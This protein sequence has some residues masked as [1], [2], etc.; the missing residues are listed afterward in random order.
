MTR[1]SR[2]SGRT[3][4]M[5]TSTVISHLPFF[6]MIISVPTELNCFHKDEFSSSIFTSSFG[7]V[8][9]AS[10]ET[11]AGGGGASSLGGRALAAASHAGGNSGICTGASRSVGKNKSKKKKLYLTGESE[12]N[13][14]S[15]FNCILVN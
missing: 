4:S 1:R 15:Y 9:A 11:G 2:V 8:V 5:Y 12:A 14:E 6:V 10:L 7:V 13:M 3:Y